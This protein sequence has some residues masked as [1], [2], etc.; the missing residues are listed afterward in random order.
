MAIPNTI[1][2][3]WIGPK[4][5]PDWLLGWK[6]LDTFK[7]RLWGEESIRELLEESY[8]SLVPLWDAYMG[9]ECYNG[10][11]N[12]ARVGI[13]HSYGGV[14]IDADTEFVA[15]FAH[16][17]FMHGG[18]FTVHSPNT[19]PHSGVKPSRL[20]NG[21]FGAERR[22]GFLNSY[23]K[24]LGKLDTGDLHPSW[25]KTGAVLMTEVF[26]RRRSG[27]ITVL[28]AHTFLPY[29]L[30]RRKVGPV[31]YGVHHYGTTRKLYD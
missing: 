11:A 2:Q 10:A 28:P 24:A 8:P 15:D 27:G 20:V 5:P 7:Y 23:A 29:D 6:N 1:H 13:V 25:K 4:D 17:G 3:I 22:H 14:Y 31:T 19:V 12:I 9:Q 21:I 16:E 30:R 26:N 18:A